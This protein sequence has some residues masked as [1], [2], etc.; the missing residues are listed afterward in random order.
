MWG[1]G[2]GAK[3]GKERLWNNEKG[4][5]KENR[6]A[7]RP[8]TRKSAILL[9]ALAQTKHRHTFSKSHTQRS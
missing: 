1:M 6:K 3:K 7:E 2:Y 5:R 8:Y 9:I 4:K